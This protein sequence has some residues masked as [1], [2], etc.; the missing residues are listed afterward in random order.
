MPQVRSTRENQASRAA[1]GHRTQLTPLPGKGTTLTNQA[2]TITP[3]SQSQASRAEITGPLRQRT[4]PNNGVV[5]QQAALA[6]RLLIGAAAVPALP[7]S[8]TRAAA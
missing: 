4:V 5:P 7:A 3:R 6:L 8:G 2:E 1:H